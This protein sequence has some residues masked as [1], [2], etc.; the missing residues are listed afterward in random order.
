MI[1]S[2]QVVLIQY[3]YTDFDVR[4]RLNRSH[5]WC[6]VSNELLMN[7]TMKYH[8]LYGSHFSHSRVLFYIIIISYSICIA[9]YNTIL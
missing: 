8:S 2:N 9:P 1:I 4:V 5:V 6:G 7:Y 3:I